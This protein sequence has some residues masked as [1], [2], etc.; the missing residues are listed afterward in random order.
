[1]TLAA[2]AATGTGHRPW[3]E[4]LCHVSSP[5]RS[6]RRPIL[7]DAPA[8]RGAL[9]TAALIVPMAGLLGAAF[10]LALAIIDDPTRSAAREFATVYAINTAGSV[11]GVAGR[12]LRAHPLA[13]PRSHAERGHR[14][15][16]CRGRARCWRVADISR[17][18]RA[19]GA[20]VGGV[21]IA[22]MLAGAPW[23]RE[24]LASGAYMYAPFAPK[25]VNLEALLKAGTLV[26]YREGAAATISVKR[27]T[28]TMT[29]AV[30]GKTDAS[31]R[32]DMLTQKLVAH[33]PLL[34]HEQP[35][36]MA[37]VGLG[38][39]VTVGAALRHP[40][41]RVDVIEIS[42]EVVE[43]S[44]VFAVENRHA[45]ADSRTHLLIGDGRSHLQLATRKYDVIASE[46][47]NPWIA[48]VAALF[49]REFFVAA[50]DRLAPG[51]LICQWANAYNIS[52]RDLR[53]IVATFL[54]VFP[55]GTAWLVGADDV[56]LLASDAPTRRAAGAPRGALAPPRCE[57]RSG[58]GGCCRAVLAVVAVR[59]RTAGAR[60]L[61]AAVAGVLTDDRMTIEF[62]GPREL[63]GR[64]VGENGAMLRA[65]LR[66]RRRSGDRSTRQV[67]RRSGRVASPRRHDVR[68]DAYSS[69]YEDYLQAL[70][71][72][73]SD[74]GA[75]DGLVRTA[76]L[77]GRGATR[78]GGSR[79]CAEGE[80]SPRDAG[81]PVEAAGGVGVRER[82]AGSRG[83]R[84]RPRRTERDALEQ[85]ASLHADD[86]D[87]AAL[88][89][90]GRAN[91]RGDARSR[92][93]RLLRG[94]AAILRGDPEQA[95]RACQRALEVSPAMPRPTTCSA[96][97]TRNSATS[98]RARAFLESLRF[99]AHDSTAYANLGVLALNDGR[100]DVAADYF[101]EALWL[102][103]NSALARQ[104]AGEGDDE[105]PQVHRLDRLGEFKGPKGYKAERN[106]VL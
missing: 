81:R 27:L 56:V 60:A 29:L 82:G 5:G 13:G 42:P 48:G 76:I 54:S 96:R 106:P 33:L 22:V 18:A 20:L 17:K 47:S 89:D 40:M 77:T 51:G 62:S 57:R 9:V 21:A 79:H 39:G 63:R 1:M 36:E 71:L 6:R 8:V 15:P 98:E 59:G 70:R 86:G 94:V 26:Y 53:S 87:G 68:R 64:T 93:D 69:A 104:G 75:L 46:P 45:L 105:T 12:W 99:D 31:N 10:P 37:I 90:D 44:N 3:R 4:A 38:S 95:R 25:G 50:R 103:A 35:R 52:D 102:D 58:V 85:L 97:R 67:G 101:A 28:G 41:A 55:H 11:A 7:F 14:L 32:G 65:L 80:A 83:A 92:G 30:D 100:A 43:A 72:D 84:E 91:A 66:Q 16:D 2:A 61:C 49:T 23:D 19:G 88:G 74:A 73:A 34:L 78:S 24:L